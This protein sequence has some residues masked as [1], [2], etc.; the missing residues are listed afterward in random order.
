MRMKHIL[1]YNG[2]V[3]QD[4]LKWGNQIKPA[5]KR[6]LSGKTLKG[7]YEL[8]DIKISDAKSN[9]EFS[10]SIGSNF[11]TGIIELYFK[12]P[13]P[14]EL[15]E[16]ISI[17]S[18]VGQGEDKR[19]DIKYEITSDSNIDSDGNHILIRVSPLQTPNFMGIEFSVFADNDYDMSYGVGSPVAKEISKQII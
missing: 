12:R 13:V 2:N 3:P 19:I 1:E 16:L 9:N 5:I 10:S 6:S 15:D 11:G 7:G 4:E 14:D 17:L 18:L 8:K